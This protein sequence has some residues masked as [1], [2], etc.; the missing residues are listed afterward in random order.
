[1]S[2]IRTNRNLSKHSI[3]VMF[4]MTELNKLAQLAAKN[5][6][7]KA[8]Y[9]RMLV[10]RDYG[11]YKTKEQEAIDWLLNGT[12]HEPSVQLGDK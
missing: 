2:M 7:S 5:K 4:T 8:E 10:A 11:D 6:M 1:M 3:H 12:G 9:I